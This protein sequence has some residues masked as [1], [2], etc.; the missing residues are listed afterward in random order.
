MRPGVYTIHLGGKIGTTNFNTDVTPE[1]IKTSDVVQFPVLDTTAAPAAPAITIWGI[2]S[3]AGV[4][5]G[6]V[7]TALGLMLIIR[8]PSKG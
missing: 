7:G 8:K 4:I 6:A 3:I 2:L 5:L 1:E